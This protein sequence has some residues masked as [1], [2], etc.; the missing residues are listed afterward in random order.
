MDIGALEIE[1]KTPGKRDGK[2]GK[3]KAEEFSS[4]R[5]KWMRA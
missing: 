3:Q 2:R 1:L 5:E 4:T